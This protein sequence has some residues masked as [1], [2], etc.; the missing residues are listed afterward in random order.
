M[1]LLLLLLC[2]CEKHRTIACERLESDKQIYL[3]IEANYDEITSIRVNEV[4]MIP[5]GIM[6]NEESMNEL[7]RQLD[8]SY[9]FEENKL[10]RSYQLFL[11]EICSL[12]ETEAYLRDLNYVCR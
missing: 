8:D 4:F 1:I 6:A 3:D 11:D 9:H 12:S 7:R 2:G 10:I 5:Y